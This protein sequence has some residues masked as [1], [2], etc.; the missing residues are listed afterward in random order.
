MA[1]SSLGDSDVSVL[2]TLGQEDEISSK[3]VDSV[4][5]KHAANLRDFAYVTP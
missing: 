2:S 1:M 3:Q 4:I 5:E